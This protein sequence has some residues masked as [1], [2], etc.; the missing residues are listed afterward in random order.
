MGL[1]PASP[2]I[3]AGTNHGPDGDRAGPASDQIFR[4]T[5][6]DP[7]SAKRQSRSVARVIPI[8][9]LA[10]TSTGPSRLKTWKGAWSNGSPLWAIVTPK[11]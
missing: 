3:R 6:R 2:T 1:S 11:A 10:V 5:K 7:T 8:L 9:G 4:L